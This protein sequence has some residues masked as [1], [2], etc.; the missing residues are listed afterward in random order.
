[1]PVRPHCL[2]AGA[3]VADE[4]ARLAGG[5]A[6]KG[7]AAVDA[8]HL[9][10]GLIVHQGL[11]AD[12]AGLDLLLCHESSPPRIMSVKN[13]PRRWRGRIFRALTSPSSPA[14]PGPRCPRPAPPGTGSRWE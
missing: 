6:G 8:G 2:P 7:P 5:V 10:G 4:V 13:R 9:P 12:Q 11:A 3:G 1:V 14:P